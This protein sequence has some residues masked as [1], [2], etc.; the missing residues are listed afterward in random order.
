MFYLYSNIF[1]HYCN[2]FPFLKIENEYKHTKKNA[3]SLTEYKNIFYKDKVEIL[4]EDIYNLL[5]H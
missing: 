5:T 1:F 3:L 4:P 2:I